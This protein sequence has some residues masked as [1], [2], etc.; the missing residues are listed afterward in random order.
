MQYAIS[1]IKWP[2][3]SFAGSSS[4]LNRTALGRATEEG[5]SPVCEWLE[6][7][8]SLRPKYHGAREIPWE[9]APTMG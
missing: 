5:D 4:Q 6:E 9:S 8:D 3:N 1:G 2:A 7:L